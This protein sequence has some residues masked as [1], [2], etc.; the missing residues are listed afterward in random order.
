MA[1]RADHRVC[2]RACHN[3]N[4]KAKQRAARD[5]RR[6]EKDDVRCAVCRVAF[7]P[8]DPGH[9]LCSRQC[10]ALRQRTDRC[11]TRGHRYRLKIVYW[12]PPRSLRYRKVVRVGPVCW[13]YSEKTRQNKG[14]LLGSPARVFQSGPCAQCGEQFTSQLRNDKLRKYC[15]KR[16]EKA[17]H[18]RHKKFRGETRKFIP[19]L[20]ADPCAYCGAPSAEIEHIVPRA[21]GGEDTW[22]NL[23]GACPT[24]NSRK[25]AKSLLN[26]L[27]S[28]V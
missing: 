20:L 10:K 9:I 18:K 5:A 26:F 8:R 23:T 14:I 6:Q 11:R 19:V 16:C 4:S 22:D 15:S 7:R 17:A 13:L 25:S 1:K 24:C 3:E 27:L 21:R 12:K 28:A 2:S